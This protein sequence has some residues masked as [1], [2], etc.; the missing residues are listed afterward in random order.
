M[1]PMNGKSL[2]LSEKPSV[3][4]IHLGLLW[5]KAKKAGFTPEGLRR[6]LV[7]VNLD[8]RAMIVQDLRELWPYV[9]EGNARKFNY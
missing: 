2:S 3:T 7:I 6:L 5:E 8:P 9:N 1:I 4:R